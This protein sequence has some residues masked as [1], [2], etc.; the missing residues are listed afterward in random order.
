[1]IARTLPGASRSFARTVARRFSGCCANHFFGHCANC[2]WLLRGCCLIFDK[3]MVSNQNTGFP[4][5]E[6]REEL[7]LVGRD[8]MTA[9]AVRISCNPQLSFPQSF[10][11]GCTLCFGLWSASGEVKR[12]SS[13]AHSRTGRSETPPPS[14]RRKPDALGVA[15]S[16]CK[17]VTNARFPQRNGRGRGGRQGRPADRGVKETARWSRRRVMKSSS[18]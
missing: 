9:D 12:R 10:K 11:S 4:I 13:D 17:L 5:S 7:R 8:E 14:H 6:S 2:A 16:G 15:R 3:G 18:E 1:V